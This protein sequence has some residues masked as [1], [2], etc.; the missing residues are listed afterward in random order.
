MIDPIHFAESRAILRPVRPRADGDLVFEQRSGLREPSPLTR[1]A[2]PTSQQSVYSGGTDSLQLLVAFRADLEKPRFVQA[3]QLGIER[4]A[5]SLRI[6]VI[7]QL[8][9]NEQRPSLL[10]PVYGSP[11]TFDGPLGPLPSTVEQSNRMLAM[12]AGGL[13][14]LIQDGASFLS[15]RLAIPLLEQSE[16]LLLCST[17]RNAPFLVT[18]TRE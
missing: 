7:E 15:A 12:V 10:G 18:F 6:D 16:A 11:W 13:H 9:Q 17:H 5:Q 1:P 3:L 14:K 8:R 4:F 2:S